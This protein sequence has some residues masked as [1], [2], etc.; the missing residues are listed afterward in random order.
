[1]KALA[2]SLKNLQLLETVNMLN[3]RIVGISSQAV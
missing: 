1:M 2:V 3:S